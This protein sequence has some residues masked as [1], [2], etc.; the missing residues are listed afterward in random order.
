MKQFIKEVY[1]TF[2]PSQW[3]GICRRSFGR[4]VGFFSKVLLLAFVLMLLLAV[5]KMIKMPGVISEQLG[6]FDV[7]RLDG[8]VTMSSPI[9][10][11]ATEPVF[12]LD[13]S[14]S[15]TTI[16]EERVLITADKVF[17][18]PFFNTREVSVADLK[19]LRNNRNEVKAFLAMMAFFVLPSII[20]YAYLLVWLK[21]FVLM[22]AL[23]LIL[24]VLLD[25]THWRRTWKELFIIS[26]H[27]ATLPVLSEVIVKAVNANLLIPV[28][29]F[30][31]ILKLYLVPAVILAVLAVGATICATLN[32]K[33]KKDV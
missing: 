27:V 31:G 30:Y 28:I 1:E 5:P 17:Y 20:F 32:E 2:L 8:N 26:C 7:L 24:F 15:Y 6:K 4:G 23:S 9:K 13:T 14:G 12:V 16:T 10:Y 22:T 33:E 18:R 29:S 3:A 21:Y 25:L 11:P 19:D